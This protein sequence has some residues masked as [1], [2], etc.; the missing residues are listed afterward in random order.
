MKTELVT[1]MQLTQK[2]YIQNGLYRVPTPEG[3]PSDNLLQGP[4]WQANAEESSGS[5][6]EF[7]V[8]WKGSEDPATINWA[9]PDYII[10]RGDISLNITGRAVIEE[11]EFY[12]LS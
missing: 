8:I 5:G 6:I 7:T 3:Q 10:A 9:E 11:N 12:S 2:P 4:W 1:K